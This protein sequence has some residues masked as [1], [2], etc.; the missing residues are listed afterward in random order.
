MKI[1]IF[2]NIQRGV[3][4]TLLI[5]AVIY[6]QMHTHYVLKKKKLIFWL[7]YWPILQNSL[8]IF[9]G[10]GFDL[11][12]N[13]KF[14]IK[15]KEKKSPNNEINAEIWSLEYYLHTFSTITDLKMAI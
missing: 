12:F 15:L 4:T 10:I 7:K 13:T 1:G 2:S 11:G 14:L 5:Y 6:F 9:I 8:K 3:V